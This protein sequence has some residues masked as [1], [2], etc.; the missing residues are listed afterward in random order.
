MVDKYIALTEF[1]RQKF[2]QGTFSAEKIIVKPNFLPD[3]PQANYGGDYAVY[4][5]RLSPEKGVDVLIKA[6]KRFPPLPLKV[7]G[8]GPQRVQLQRLASSNV[9][10]VGQIEKREVL[11]LILQSRFLIF[12]SVLYETFGR[13]IIEAFACGKPVIASRLGSAAEIVEDKKTGFLFEPGNS[14][15][16]AAKAKLLIDDPAFAVQ[17][18]Q[19]ARAEFEA[20]YTAEKN[21]EQLMSIYNSVTE[22]L[23][24]LPRYL[25]R[26]SAFRRGIR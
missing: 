18:G 2:I 13:A 24:S 1:S 21:Y 23:A 17:L 6:W 20:K 26:L 9:E 12:P 25:S 10:F 5:G 16:L 15:E 8:D 4:V 19:N 7:A 3:P 22:R 14:D 11:N